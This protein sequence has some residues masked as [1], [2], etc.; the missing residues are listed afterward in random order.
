MLG[1]FGISIFRTTRVRDLFTAARDTSLAASKQDL[2]LKE[3]NQNF[4]ILSANE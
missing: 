3:L 1:I 2:L 4:Q